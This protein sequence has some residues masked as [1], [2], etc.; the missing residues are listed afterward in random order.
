MQKEAECCCGQGRDSQPCSCETNE[1]ATLVDMDAGY[2]K[3]KNKHFVLCYLYHTRCGCLL[4][5][6]GVLLGLTR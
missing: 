4:K 3:D 6:V 2:G 1:L 5:Y